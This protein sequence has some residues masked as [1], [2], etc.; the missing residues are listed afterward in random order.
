[1]SHFPDPDAWVRNM[2]AKRNAMDTY[3]QV[4]ADAAARAASMAVRDYTEFMR[5]MQEFQPADIAKA[6]HAFCRGV[7]FHGC[8]KGHL[9]EVFALRDHSKGSHYGL[10][11]VSL[12]A[13][14]A[15]AEKFRV[16]RVQRRQAGE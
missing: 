1:M 11:G 3:E 10:H 6:F 2:A 13:I 12:E 9:A 14:V 4:I 7:N 8:P 15:E 5:R 16:R